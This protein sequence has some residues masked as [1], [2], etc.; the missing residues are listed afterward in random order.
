MR[1]IDNTN[2]SIEFSA[3]QVGECFYYDNCLFIKINPVKE[4]HHTAV[5]N[6]LCFAD[7]NVASVP[8]DWNV[9]PV[10]AEIIIRSK[11]VQE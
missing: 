1:I 2:T 8:N 7:N 4:E 5:C 11:G 9:T 6:A 10:N 3:V